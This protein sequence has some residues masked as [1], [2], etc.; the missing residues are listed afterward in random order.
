[1]NQEDQRLIALAENKQWIWH[2]YAVNNSD[3]NKGDQRLMATLTSLVVMSEQPTD[4]LI[5]LDPIKLLTMNNY[6]LSG[7]RYT[8]IYR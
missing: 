8:C 5:D 6:F 2:N 4:S 7:P 3:N 1:M